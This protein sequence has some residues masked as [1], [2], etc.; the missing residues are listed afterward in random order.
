MQK[1]IN[2]GLLPIQY[3]EL[4]DAFALNNIKGGASANA[5]DEEYEIIYIDGK[6]VLVRRSSTGQIIEILSA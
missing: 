4:F 5:A 2:I 3:V 1:T 6:P